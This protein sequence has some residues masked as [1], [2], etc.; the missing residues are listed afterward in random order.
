MTNRTA[1]PTQIAAFETH[2][3]ARFELVHRELFDE[4]VRDASEQLGDMQLEELVAILRRAARSSRLVNL[5][6]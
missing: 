1:S 5:L 3:R 4:L 2:A 6:Q